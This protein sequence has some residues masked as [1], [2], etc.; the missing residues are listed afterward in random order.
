MKNLL[1]NILGKSHVCLAI[2]S[3]MIATGIPRMHSFFFDSPKTQ[4][5]SFIQAIPIEF[6]L[7]LVIFFF[8]K[9]IG[10]KQVGFQ[11]PVF[12]K[13]YWLIPE[14]LFIGAVM[15]SINKKP[16]AAS[17]KIILLLLVLAIM[18]GLYEELLS[19][20]IVLHVLARTGKIEWAILGSGFIFGILHFSNFDGS[21]G[22]ETF[23]QIIETFAAGVYTAVIA[24]ALRSVIPLMVT[25]FIYDFVLFKSTYFEEISHAIIPVEEVVQSTSLFDFT[26][27][28]VPIIYVLIAMIVYYFEKDN[29]KEYHEDLLKASNEKI[30]FSN[31]NIF[32]IVCVLSIVVLSINAFFCF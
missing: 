27:Y 23:Q 7:L 2:A 26:Y 6:F 16:E 31:K 17:M 29:I 30:K 9:N 12:K 1:E 5:L 18:V 4:T 21:N 32:Q 8:G 20:G 14:A 25:H 3:I 11:K 13:F 28:I 22:V 24:L 19:R 15:F 10:F